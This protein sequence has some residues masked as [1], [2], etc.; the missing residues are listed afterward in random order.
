LV[1]GGLVLV[2]GALFAVWKSGQDRS[3][4]PRVPVEVNGS[5]SLRVDQELVDLGDVPLDKTVTVS[6]QLTNVGDDTLRFDQE[7]YIKV[8]EGC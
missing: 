7:P 6:F 2:G 8:L 4:G 1:L 3:A 5:P